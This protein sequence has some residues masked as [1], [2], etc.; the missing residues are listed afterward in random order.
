[1]RRFITLLLV[2]WF[3]AAVPCA[4]AGACASKAAMRCPCCAGRAHCAC[5]GPERQAPVQGAGL[6][7]PRT[8]PEHA[9]EMPVASGTQAV[10]AGGAV[11]P[12]ASVA[13]ATSAL[14]AYLSACTFR[15]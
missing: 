10:A 4:V 7:A 9:A 6:P 2:G 15:C 3:A 5:R 11:A 1:M 13:A 12:V 14:P 8:A